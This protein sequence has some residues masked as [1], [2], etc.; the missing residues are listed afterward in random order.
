MGTS[1]GI[2]AA[3]ACAA[4]GAQYADVQ[5]VQ[6]E[7]PPVCFAAIL[8]QHIHVGVRIL[9]AYSDFKAALTAKY[10]ACGDMNNQQFSLSYNMRAEATQ[11]PGIS[12]QVERA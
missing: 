4:R 5:A 7:S 1:L 12:N 11:I 10:G 8:H 2:V 9:D 3:H 6:M